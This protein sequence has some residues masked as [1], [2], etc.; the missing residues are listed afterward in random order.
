MQ[1][2]TEKLY[3]CEATARELNIKLGSLEDEHHRTKTELQTLR[4]ENMSLDGSCH[5][6]EKQLQQL[7]TKLAVVDQEVKDKEQLLS[8]SSDLLG[9][10]QSQKVRCVCV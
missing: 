6:Q 7:R 3:K 4:K 9:T 5:E 8:K 2:L 1:D 10:E